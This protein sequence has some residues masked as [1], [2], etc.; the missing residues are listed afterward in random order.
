[1]SNQHATLSTEPTGLTL[2]TA[3]KQI[4]IAWADGHQS[5]YPFWYLRGFC[6]CAMCQGHQGGW[7]FIADVPH[8][9]EDVAE[10]GRYA[11]N[12]VYEDGHRTGIYSFEILRTLCPCAVCQKADPNHPMKRV[13]KSAHQRT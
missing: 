1:M 2:Q 13:P 5:Q 7:D 4:T 11:L 12:I 9:V 8:T 3:E 10:V 6:P